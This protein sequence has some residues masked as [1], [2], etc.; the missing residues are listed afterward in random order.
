M[1]LF[2]HKAE[3]AVASKEPLSKR[4]LTPVS[5]RKFLSFFTFS[6]IVLFPDE[7]K[8]SEL[9]MSINEKAYKAKRSRLFFSY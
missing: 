9:V 6:V 4:Y 7:K 5:A 1:L 3:Y 2:F 8:I